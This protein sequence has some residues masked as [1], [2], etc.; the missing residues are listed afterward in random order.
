MPVIPALVVF[1]FCIQYILF[2]MHQPKNIQQHERCVDN[3][4]IP[5]L[6]YTVFAFTYYCRMSSNSAHLYA[7]VNNHA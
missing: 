2:H 4:N 1:L 7:L 5:I 6:W 3:T